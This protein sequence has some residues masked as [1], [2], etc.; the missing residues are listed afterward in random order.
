[1]KKIL[2]PSDFSA[3]AGKALEFA[4]QCSKILPAEVILIHAFE[5]NG[6]IYTDYMGVNR[7]FNQSLL[8]DAHRKLES[9][10]ENIEVREGVVITTKL[11]QFSLEESI[12]QAT[13]DQGIDFIVMGT[14]G[15]SGLKEKLFGSRTASVIGKSPVPVLAIPHEYNWKKPEKILLATNHFEEEPVLLNFLF[16]IGDLMLAQVQAVVF[17]DEDDDKAV[18]FLEHKRKIPQYEQVLKERYKEERLSVVHLYG[19]EFEEK[20]QEY[21]RQNEI[22]ILA[23]ITYHKKFSERLFHPSLT[24]KM[25]YHTTIP[26]LAIPAKMKGT[27]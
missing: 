15:A 26:L 22:D 24:K 6:D 20:L 16:E 13:R 17:T 3:C 4:V 11:Y 2:V 1:M 14:S 23:M 10:R 8:E 25:S 19:T 5:I 18:T 9:L 27:T 21:I 7:E 12:L